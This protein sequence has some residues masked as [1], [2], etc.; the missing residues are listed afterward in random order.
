LL[1]SSIPGGNVEL[2]PLVGTACHYI[3]D[4]TTSSNALSFHSSAFW[5]ISNVT[6]KWYTFHVYILDITHYINYQIDC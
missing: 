4:H 1:S 6:L 5:F 2:L 3:L